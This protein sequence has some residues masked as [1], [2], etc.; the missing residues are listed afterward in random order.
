VFTPQSVSST[1]VGF[2]VIPAGTVGV[3]VAGAVLVALHP[4]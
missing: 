2:A 1:K 4:L 3:T